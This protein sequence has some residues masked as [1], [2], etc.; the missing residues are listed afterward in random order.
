MNEPLPRSPRDPRCGVWSRLGAV[1]CGIVTPGTGST[2]RRA[3]LPSG[4]RARARPIGRARTTILFSILGIALTTLPGRAA[5]G[6]SAPGFALRTADGILH[7]YP[8][9]DLGSTRRYRVSDA[10]VRA[11]VSA[12]GDGTWRLAI[13]RA[14]REIREVYFP[15]ESRRVP[16][17]DD[18]SDDL[19]LS[20]VRLGTAW[21]VAAVNRDLFWKTPNSPMYPGG[22]AAPFTIVADPDDARIVA[23][24]HWPPKSV[25]PQFGSQGMVLQFRNPVPAGASDRF[26]VLIADVHGPIAWQRAVDRYRSWLDRHVPTPV[27]PDW[28]WKGEG[29]LNVQLQNQKTFSVAELRKR[30]QSTRDLYPWIVFWGQMSPYA[31]NCCALESG[32]HPRYD[33]GLVEFVRDEI[34]GQGYHAAF[35]S[36]PMYGTATMPPRSLDTPE[37][38]RFLTDWIARHRERFANAFYVDT[39]GAT[40]HGEAATILELARSGA[41]P[42]EAII[43]GITDVYPWASLVSGSLTGNHPACGAPHKQPE[44]WDSAP[45]PRLVRYLLGDRLIFL[46]GSNND[47]LFWGDRKGWLQEIRFNTLCDYREYCAAHGPCEHWTE[48]EVFLLG[49]KFDMLWPEGNPV[50]DRIVEL[51]RDAGWWDRRPTYLDT[52]GLDL[53]GIPKDARVEVRRHRDKDGFDLL[54]VSN[55]TGTSGLRFRIDGKAIPIPIPVEPLSLIDLREGPA[56]RPAPKK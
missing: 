8:K 18:V 56:G 43:E 46:G 11:A 7:T 25:R 19:Y 54:T 29:F 39:L 23:A 17:D 34:V 52:K 3:F 41:I 21:K 26:D 24:I 27:Y 33:P 51:R 37:G 38:V 47:W 30:W 13:D 10:V 42:R 32:I 50:V 40:F 14:R 44:D 55:E 2:E 49:A 12:T 1:R 48:R 4:E 22:L 5:T 31:G 15:W 20:P 53:T 45:F 28:M 6:R 9:H 16:L 36:A 35:Y